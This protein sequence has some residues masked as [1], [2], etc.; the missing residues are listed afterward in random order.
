MNQVISALSPTDFYWLLKEHLEEG[1]GEQWVKGEVSGMNINQQRLIFFDLKDEQVSVRCFILFHELQALGVP[2]ENGMEIMVQAIPS[3]FKRNTGFHLRVR[4]VQLVGA[5]ALQKAYE[6]LK[7]KLQKEGLFD[8][9]RK[10]PL[11]S[12]PQRIGVI[13]SPEAAAW[14]DFQA[15]AKNR[16]GG[17]TLSLF[18]VSVQGV[19]APSQIVQAFEWFNVHSEEFDLVVL[20]RGGG[21]LEDLWAFNDE[22]VARQVFSSKLP[23]VVGVGHERDETLADFVADVRAST[24]SNAAE[25]IVPERNELRYHVDRLVRDQETS[26]RHLL[27][28]RAHRLSHGVLILQSRFADEVG[29]VRALLQR[30]DQHAEQFR[31]RI[32]RLNDQVKVA[33]TQLSQKFFF[34]LERQRDR[35]ANMERVIRSLNPTRLLS[36][37]YA[38]SFDVHGRVVTSTAQ[39][40]LG[41]EMKSVFATGS[42]FSIIKRKQS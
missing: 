12:F 25:R 23:V 14:T 26:I 39:L 38:L 30:F 8:P 21:S 42:A 22:R 10:R 20:T 5:G 13:T 17:L 29:R 32:Q 41:D 36:R 19:G 6:Q 1:L 2:L 18:P 40:K 7:A 16:M 24:P 27:T 15:M 34:H 11:P 9:E 28:E 33:G 4:A 3:A 31:S 35:V 37:G